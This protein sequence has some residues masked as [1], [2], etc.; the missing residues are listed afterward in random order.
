MK[1]IIEK[2]WNG[3]AICFGVVFGIAFCGWL[4]GAIAIL[5]LNAL[6]PKFPVHAVM[7]PANN[8][9][10]WRSLVVIAIGCVAIVCFLLIRS[11]VSAPLRALIE[12]SF[13]RWDAIVA[14]RS[15]VAWVAQFILPKP[16]PEEIRATNA[17][18]ERSDDFDKRIWTKEYLVSYEADEHEIIKHKK[19]LP[20][21]PRLKTGGQIRA[22]FLGTPIV[23]LI[24]YGVL[25]VST[26]HTEDTDDAPGADNQEQVAVET[27]SPQWFENQALQHWCWNVVLICSALGLPLWVISSLSEKRYLK[28]LGAD[29]TYAEADDGIH[30]AD[31]TNFESWRQAF[32]ERHGHDMSAEQEKNFRGKVDKVI[33]A[34]DQEGAALRKLSDKSDEIQ[35]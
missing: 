9:A 34:Y 16:S 13:A 31:P 30:V 6:L 27:A 17:W 5:L 4:A 11:L 8:I 26:R 15:N 29:V 19:S 33:D 20:S 2:I 18:K 21:Y 28:M 23:L 32:I 7:P 35:S 24:A 22:W 1:K 14:R 3:V 25:F 12:K 10:D